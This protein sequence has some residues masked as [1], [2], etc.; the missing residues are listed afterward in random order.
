MFLKSED[1]TTV[2]TACPTT[3]YWSG[4]CVNGASVKCRPSGPIKRRSHSKI[5]A[6]L[7]RHATITDGFM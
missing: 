1:F 6:S 3:P 7:Q 2:P 4:K 5:R